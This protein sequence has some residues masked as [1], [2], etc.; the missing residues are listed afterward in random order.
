MGNLMNKNRALKIVCISVLCLFVMALLF[1][2][3]VPYIANLLT[4]PERSFHN[5][6]TAI[7]SESE[8]IPCV[9]AYGKIYKDEKV[10]SIFDLCE[11][12]DKSYLHTLCVFEN[13]V[14]FICSESDKTNHYWTIA[15]VDLN[16]L[17]MQTHFRFK[18]PD[19]AYDEYANTAEYSKQN[20]YYADGK[21]VLNDFV[22][23]WEYDLHS[24]SSKEYSYDKYNFTVREIYG[25]M[26]D[27]NAISVHTP[28][29]EKTFTFYEMS[30]ESVGISTI[31]SFRDRKMWNDHPYITNFFNEKSVQYVNGQIYAIGECNDR[32]GGAYAIILEYDERQDQWKYVTCIYIWSPAAEAYVIPKYNETVAKQHRTGAFSRR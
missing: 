27:D 11:K 12:Q 20:G 3:S 24:N 28:K 19:R 32:R 17:E 1:F 9:A 8:E 30:Q 29:W 22:S 2:I 26:V 13:R 23:V 31:Y 7:T 18:N 4:Q 5:E 25:N 16:A 21:I 15:S 10:V 14:Y 6:I